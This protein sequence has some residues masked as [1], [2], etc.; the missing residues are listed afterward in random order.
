MKKKRDMLECIRD[1]TAQWLFE[2]GSNVQG[3]MQLLNTVSLQNQSK[4]EKFCEMPITERRD[5]I[6]KHYNGICVF[7]KYLWKIMIDINFDILSKEIETTDEQRKRLMPQ[8]YINDCEK[9]YISLKFPGDN[10]EDGVILANIYDEPRTNVS[11]IFS[12][13]KKFQPKKW[14]MQGSYRGKYSYKM[15]ISEIH[16]SYKNGYEVS[17]I[18]PDKFEIECMECIDVDMDGWNNKEECGECIF[19]NNCI[20]QKENKE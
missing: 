8:T 2:L 15:D 7:L 12:R 11:A 20:K 6:C 14:Y 5:I 13:M 3:Q 4:L 10:V 18:D 19:N 16:K 1:N 9:N 17:S